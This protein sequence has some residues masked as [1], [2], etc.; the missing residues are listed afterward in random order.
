MVAKEKSHL[1]NFP[2]ILTPDLLPQLVRDLAA[3]HTCPGN[4][5]YVVQDCVLNNKPAYVHYLPGSRTARHSS[6][7]LITSGPN[8]CA[9]CRMYRSNLAA[10]FKRCSNTQSS[11]APKTNYRHI[12]HSKLAKRL[13]ISKAKGKIMK[14]RISQLEGRIQ[15]LFEDEALT[16]N[17][18]SNNAF[19]EVFLNETDNV[20]EEFPEKL[21]QKLLWEEQLK[22]LKRNPKGMQW[23]PAIIRLCIALSAKS[24]SAYE[25]L[26]TSG[27]LSLPTQRTLRQLYTQFTKNTTGF[28]KDFIDRICTDLKLDTMI[29]HQ[30]NI[31]L[32]L[33]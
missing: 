27:F 13:N 12:Q 20:K 15:R 16:I 26:Q 23:H 28:N 7:P 1:T 5:E 18:E 29:E 30:K 3:C 2:D 11:P 14:K 9:F 6:C 4:P 24:S 8:R 32:A 19:K 33:D 17:K 21:P 22:R 10:I 25:L 31:T